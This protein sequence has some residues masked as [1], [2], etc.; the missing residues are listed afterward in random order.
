[1]G[2]I[3]KFIH[4]DLLNLHNNAETGTVCIEEP[5]LPKVTVCELWPWD[6]EINY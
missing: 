1:M 2:I 4:G 6:A 5:K 3:L